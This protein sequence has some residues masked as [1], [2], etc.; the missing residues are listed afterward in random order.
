M[1]SEQRAVGTERAPGYRV[2]DAS[3][4]KQFRTYKEQ[5]IQF[6]AMRST[7]A[8]SASYSAPGSTATSTATFGQITSTLSPARQIQYSLK[9]EF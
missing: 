6:R 1:G 4:F 8:T 3:A 7:W 9:Y 5:F 2:V